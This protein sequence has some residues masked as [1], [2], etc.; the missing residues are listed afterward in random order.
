MNHY[1]LTLSYDGT[2]YAGWQAQAG[3]NTIQQ[4]VEEALAVLFREPTRLHASGRTDRGVHARAQEAHFSAENA[5]PRPQKLRRAL[6]ALLPDTIRIQRAVP[7][8]ESFH[9]RFSAIRKEYR[10]FI[11]NGEVMPP[12]LRNY[13]LHARRKLNLDA[14]R[15]A[16]ERLQGTHDF[17]AFTANPKRDVSS[18][19]RILNELSVSKKGNEI[20][21]RA[22]ANG[23]LYK[24]VRSLAGGLVRVGLGELKP[25]EM[26]RILESRERTARIPT[27][28]PQGLFLWK[29]TY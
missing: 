7:V 16:A 10:Y 25:E 1:R 15:S 8:E 6:N 17:A 13:R 14:M 26:T 23:F 5:F 19:V 9:A 2:D 22:V 18:T 24:M 29:V 20:Q 11:W 27:A 3:E 28:L 21:L 4:N 12:F